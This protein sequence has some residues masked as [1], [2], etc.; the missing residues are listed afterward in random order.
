MPLDLVIS[1]I[2]PVVSPI[3]THLIK[4]FIRTNKYKRFE[5]TWCAYYREPGAPGVIKEE[6]WNFSGRGKVSVTRN[7]VPVYTGNVEVSGGKAYM[8]VA[9]VDGDE[10]FLVMMNSSFTGLGHAINRIHCIWLGP[11]VGQKT[12]AGFAVLSKIGIN[13]QQLDRNIPDS[14]LV[15]EVEGM[16][17]CGVSLEGG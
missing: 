14:F 17:I 15:C 16:G 13:A 5:G 11:G 6:Q 7:S 10:Q 4:A 3:V 8:R 1:A 9:A 2:K 12:S